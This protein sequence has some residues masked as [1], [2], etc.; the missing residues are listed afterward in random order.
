[1]QEPTCVCLLM[2]LPGAQEGCVEKRHNSCMKKD[3]G[4]EEDQPCDSVLRIHHA[5]DTIFFSTPWLVL[6]NL[7]LGTDVEIMPFLN[8]APCEGCLA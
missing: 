5:L 2:Y 1:M 3:H 4:F 7:W 8:W 6:G